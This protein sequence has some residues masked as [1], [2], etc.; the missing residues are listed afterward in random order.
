MPHATKTR[1]ADLAEWRR[2]RA[3]ELAQQGWKQKDIA[4]ALA[5]TPG[6]VSQWLKRARTAGPAALTKQPHPGPK[7]KLTD[8]QL[9]QIP[10]LLAQGAEAFGFAGAV[11]TTKR[12]AAVIQQIFGVRYHPA[13]I[14]RLVRMFRWS[15]QT[16]TTVATQRDAAAV[17]DWYATRWPAL[18]K[19][20][21]T[22]TAPSSG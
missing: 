19:K 11:W 18:K 13:H 2:H 10:A 21:R 22:R 5:V 6:A 12:I 4:T 15:V 9:A 7:P 20:R 17:A 16:P 14:S 8:D 1:S 3:W